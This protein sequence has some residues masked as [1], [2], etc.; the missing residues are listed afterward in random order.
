MHGTFVFCFTGFD[1]RGLKGKFATYSP[2]YLRKSVTSIKFSADEN[3][4]TCLV[5][6]SSGIKCCERSVIQ[7]EEKI[8]W[9]FSHIQKR[10]PNWRF[11]RGHFIFRSRGSNL[12]RITGSPFS[13]RLPDFI[14]CKDYRQ[15]WFTSKKLLQY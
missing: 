1:E 9:F 15:Q 11:H 12:N 8:V 14:G 7:W 4:V 10:E 13:F 5:K 2:K 3:P 6:S